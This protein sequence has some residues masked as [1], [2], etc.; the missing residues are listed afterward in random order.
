MEHR[1]EWLG[2]KLKPL[3][4]NHLGKALEYYQKSVELGEGAAYLGIGAVYAEMKELKKCIVNYRKAALCGVNTKDLSVM[5]R[6]GWL[7]ELGKVCLHAEET[8]GGLL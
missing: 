6:C 7:Y 8:A 3:V 1:I 5:L 2:E 4:L